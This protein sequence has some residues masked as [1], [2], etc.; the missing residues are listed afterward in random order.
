M[1]TL[2]EYGLR[3][4]CD[5]LLADEC[6]KDYELKLAALAADLQPRGT[7]EERQV[8]LIAGWDSTR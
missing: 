7:L 8:E 6:A 5:F 2:T 4:P 1:G 3:D